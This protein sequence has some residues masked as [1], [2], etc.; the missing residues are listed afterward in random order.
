[1]RSLFNKPKKAQHSYTINGKTW[2]VEESMQFKVQSY[3]EDVEIYGWTIEQKVQNYKGEWI[4]MPYYTK[5]IYDFRDTAI[6]AA[7]SIYSKSDLE[8]RVS[9]L[10][11]MEKPEWRNYQID[12]L[13][14]KLEEVKK[15]DE[16]KSWIVKEDYDTP[17]QTKYGTLYKV[18][19]KKGDVFI[20]MGDHVIISAT[21]QKPTIYHQK[22]LLDKYLI[23]NELVREID[24]KELT[25]LYPHFTKKVKEK[26]KIN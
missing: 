12:K 26:L 25:K 2:A 15:D 17:F 22:Y 10:Y 18:N 8:W 21:T 16:V 1:M 13:I 7:I 20:Q 3:A 24:I 11:R 5:R 23:P 14:N 4:W 6:S 19:V 9:P